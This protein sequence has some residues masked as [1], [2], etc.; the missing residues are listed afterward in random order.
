MIS[1]PMPQSSRQRRC[2]ICVLS[3]L[4]GAAQS[5]VI[6]SDYRGTPLSH[7]HCVSLL[8]LLLAPTLLQTQTENIH[9][10]ARKKTGC[11]G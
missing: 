9:W 10:A 1:S 2:Q 11:I 3:S 7:R 8:R 6:F 5:L 4:A